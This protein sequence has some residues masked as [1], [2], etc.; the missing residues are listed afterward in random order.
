M[1]LLPTQH[2]LGT[3]YTCLFLGPSPQNLSQEVVLRDDAFEK[4]DKGPCLLRK[5]LL[6]PS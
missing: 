2:H 5:T 4:D 3:H 1:P 6:D